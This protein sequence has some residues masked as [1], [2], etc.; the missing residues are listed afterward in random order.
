LP[1]SIASMGYRRRDRTREVPGQWPRCSQR[2]AVAVAEWLNGS[3][4]SSAVTA[5]TA[6]LGGPRRSVHAG[7]VTTCV[8]VQRSVHLDVQSL[9]ETC[10][11]RHST[12]RWLTYSSAPI[13]RLVRPSRPSLAIC[14]SWGVCSHRGCRLGA[15]ARSRQWPAPRV[16]LCESIPVLEKGRSHA[17]PFPSVGSVLLSRWTADRG[18]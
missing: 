6:M 8:S 12:V 9:R 10:R 15:C 2:L 3:R 17:P 5:S 18:N 13:S 14:L 7:G 16:A 4:S 1:L 11:R